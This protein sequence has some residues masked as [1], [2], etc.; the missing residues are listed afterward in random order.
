VSLKDGTKGLQDDR[1]LAVQAV[2]PMLPIKENG[3]VKIDCVVKT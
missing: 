1:I 3:P 2:E